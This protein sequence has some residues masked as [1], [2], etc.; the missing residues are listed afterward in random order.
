MIGH[1]RNAAR[2]LRGRKRTDIFRSALFEKQSFRSR[3]LAL[4]LAIYS[5]LRLR[6]TFALML[7]C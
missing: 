2:L 4:A 3:P 1:Q 5:Q 7:L 6:T